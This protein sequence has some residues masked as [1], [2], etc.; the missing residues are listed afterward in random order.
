MPIIRNFRRRQ[1]Y[2]TGDVDV[3]THYAGVSVRRRRRIRGHHGSFGFW[4]IHA[5]EHHWAV[6]IDRPQASLPT[7]QSRDIHTRIEMTWLMYAIKFLFSFFRTSTCFHARAL[8][9]TSNSHS[10]IV[11]LA[12]RSGTDVQTAS[13]E[14]VGLQGRLDH[15]PNQLSGGQ[16]QTG[17][18]LQGT[19]RRTQVVSCDEPTGNLDST[20]SI[21]VIGAVSGTPASRHHGGV[22]HSRARHC[23]V[24]VTGRDGA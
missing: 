12:A 14:R 10:S 22:G 21:E 8:W 24:C 1:D 19:G 11:E 17:W 23:R 6:S 2:R 9:K 15:T 7:C 16:Q 13:L 3:P 20:T 5:H 4:K 18:P